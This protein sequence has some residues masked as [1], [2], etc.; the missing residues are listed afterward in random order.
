MLALNAGPWGVCLKGRWWLQVLVLSC[1]IG[2]VH[3]TFIQ[4]SCAAQ[5]AT[6][7]VLSERQRVLCMR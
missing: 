5:W 6:S 7:L 2:A 3:S 1:C 4:P